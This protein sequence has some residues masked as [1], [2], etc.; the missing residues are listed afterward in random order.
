[1]VSA[2]GF[3]A[4]L[5]GSFGVTTLWHARKALKA[6][7]TPAEIRLALQED[8]I[9]RNEEIRFDVGPPTTAVDR[10]ANFVAAAGLGLMAA[11]LPLGI[12]TTGDSSSAMLSIAGIGGLAG[13]LAAGLRAHRSQKRADIAGERW[14]KVWRGRIGDALFKVAGLRVKST[15]GAP[16]GAHRSTEVMLG[17][18]ANSFGSLS[19]RRAVKLPA[20]RER[21]QGIACEGPPQTVR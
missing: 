19:Q 7:F 2:G 3:M 4:M 12:L 13:L 8:V 9:R 11:T 16:E 1:M 21:E 15:G 6:G 10:V 5:A 17:L 14:L 18:A 20:D